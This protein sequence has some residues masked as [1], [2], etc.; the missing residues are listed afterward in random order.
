MSNNLNLLTISEFIDT[1]DSSLD[2]KIVILLDEF[3]GETVSFKKQ[4]TP[5]PNGKY[6]SRIKENHDGSIAYYKRVITNDISIKIAEIH[7]D[8]NSDDSTEIQQLIN[9]MEAGQVLNLE[10]NRYMLHS[11][12]QINKAIKIKGSST[13]SS[14][15]LPPFLITK[16]NNGIVIN[17]SGVVLEGFG[18]YNATY[19][20]AAPNDFTGIKVNGTSSNHTYDIIL[21]DLLIN[22]YKTAL[23]VNYLWS[24]QI[25][26][27]KTHDCQVGILVKGKSVNNEIS[28]NTS[29]AFN[30]NT[31]DSKGIWFYGDVEK[32]GW[33][34]I[35]TLIYGAYDAIY[36]EKTSHVNFMN[37]MIDFC[38]HI[39]IVLLDDCF[40]WNINSNYIALFNP[41]YGIYSANNVVNPLMVRGHKIIDNDILMYKNDN[42][43]VIDA[44]S[45]GVNIV[46]SGSLYD[47]VRGNSVKNFKVYDIKANEGL[48]TTISN[49]KCLSVIEPNISGNFITNDNLG[50]V[51]YQNLND[52][53]HLG[54]VKITYA[55]AYPTTPSSQWKRGDIILN[56]GPAVDAPIG[57]VNTTD[58]TNTWKPF[59]IINP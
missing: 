21:K 44:I 7:G 39:G 10:N 52:S 57:W 15:D 4:D 37:S 56:V 23:E 22:G 34:I 19:Y 33:R 58:G 53:L 48:K 6:L 42:P 17:T 49:N 51:Y 29:L 35:D 31:A 3:S 45:I 26:T 50:T 13:R 43:N 11:P 55:D 32:E 38:Q 18:I 24:S 41:G 1:H 54:K 28:G 27:L 16:N 2:K 40:N 47:D 20:T 8:G 46:G 12:I 5:V 25:Q 30:F 59:G 36:A 9:E 14:V